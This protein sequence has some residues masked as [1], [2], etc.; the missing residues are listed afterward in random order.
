MKRWI[1]GTSLLVFVWY[2]V[3]LF[4]LPGIGGGEPVLPLLVRGSLQAHCSEICNQHMS[5][6][7]RRNSLALQR[8]EILRGLGNRYLVVSFPS[9]VSFPVGVVVYPQHRYIY[10]HNFVYR[11]AF[12]NWDAH[13]YPTF[14]LTRDGDFFSNDITG[15]DSR[16][17]P[18][19]AV[20]QE[21]G[22]TRAWSFER[23]LALTPPCN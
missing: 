23:R 14:L 5:F 2:G 3:V 10:R 11:L 8:I 20:L 19:D 17:P 4:L 7:D 15:F 22:E 6:A 21:L 9:Q 1:I 18:T 12:W 13:T 16:R